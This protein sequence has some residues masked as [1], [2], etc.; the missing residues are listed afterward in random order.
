MDIT[1]GLIMGVVYAATPG[2]V[3]VATVRWGIRN[4]FLACLAL[5][6]GTSVGRFSY[7]LL[8]LF[9]ARVLLQEATLQLA[10]GVFGAGVLFYLGVTAIRDG[11]PLLVSDGSGEPGPA[12][13]TRAFWTGAVLSLAS[14]LAVVF[15]LSIGSRVLHDPGLDGPAFLGGFFLGCLFTSLVVAIL[16]GWGRS[17]LTARVVRAV[18]WACGLA[19]IVFGLQMGLSMGADLI[20]W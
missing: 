13:K 6:A 7:A 12:T 15:W 5:Q 14:P 1:S 2:P 19:L 4:G 8:A 11:R 9:G 3:N 10:M 17:R 16:V 18:S 20:A